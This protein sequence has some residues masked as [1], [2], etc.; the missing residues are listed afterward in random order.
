M[1][2]IRSYYVILL[3]SIKVPLHIYSWETMNWQT[4]HLNLVMM[5]ALV[6][7]AFNGKYIVGLIPDKV[8]RYLIYTIIFIAACML[9]I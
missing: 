4:L 8:Y 7:G 3:N 5:P 9:F 2:A 6:L 1:Y